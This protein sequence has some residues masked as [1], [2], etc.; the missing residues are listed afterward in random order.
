MNQ[1]ID[2][3]LD[4]PGQ[5]LLF[6]S[7]KLWRCNIMKLADISNGPDWI[8]WAVFLILAILSAVLISGHGICGYSVY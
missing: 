6:E 5:I 7:W 4:L 2:T 3:Q 1:H 8:V